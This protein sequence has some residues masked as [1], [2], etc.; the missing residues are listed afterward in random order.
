MALNEI[1]SFWYGVP[2]CWGLIAD[3]ECSCSLPKF[4]TTQGEKWESHA[5]RLNIVSVTVM[6]YW[7]EW[8]DILTRWLLWL[9]VTNLNLGT[10]HLKA[11]LGLWSR[12]TQPG[13]LPWTSSEGR[14][15]FY[16]EVQIDSFHPVKKYGPVAITHHCTPFPDEA[17][18][19][20]W[21]KRSRVFMGNPPHGNWINR[22]WK[23][24]IGRLY[25]FI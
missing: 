5:W 21:D 25:S 18:S 24:P 17:S 9:P 1:A 7:R 15:H 13:F 22:S 23:F 19:K 6:T 12:L 20:G 4:K 10:V 16:S 3:K 11:C 14:G 2:S 8:P